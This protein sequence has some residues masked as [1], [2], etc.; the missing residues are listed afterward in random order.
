VRPVA[1]PARGTAGRRPPVPVLAA[2]LLGL[3]ESV[4]LLAVG[5]TGLDGLIASPLRPQGWIVATVLVLLAGWV[6][7]CAGGGATL[8]DGSGRRLMGA[9]AYAE[10]VLVGALFVVALFAGAGTTA[11]LPAAPGGLPLPALA[12][13][14]VAV[15]VGKLLLAGTP[16]ALSWVAAGPQARDRRPDPVAAHRLLCTLTIAGIGLALGAVAVLAPAPTASGTPATSI[17]SDR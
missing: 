12:L 5:L 7:L 14:A 6:V 10:L 9:V 1:E 8:L 17:V 15:P 3:A 4:A 2:G 13:L 11:V 16:S